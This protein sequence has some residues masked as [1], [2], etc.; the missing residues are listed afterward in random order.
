MRE[1]KKAGGGGGGGGRETDRD[2]DTETERDREF[3][4]RLLCYRLVST[5]RIHY[6]VATVERPRFCYYLFRLFV[7]VGLLSLG[8]GGGGQFI[9]F[10][11]E[12]IFLVHFSSIRV[13]AKASPQVTHPTMPS[14]SLTPSSHDGTTVT[15]KPSGLKSISTP[16]LRA[17]AATPQREGDGG[18]E[19]GERGG[20]GRGGEPGIDK[21]SSPPSAVVSLLVPVSSWTARL[22]TRPHMAGYAGTPSPASLYLCHAWK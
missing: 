7:V 18:K 22:Q 14:P 3:S 17:A 5:L 16:K 1:R 4:M 13:K 10:I 21:S 11:C 12:I 6:S 15:D 9:L 2:R 19:R 8:G 20:G